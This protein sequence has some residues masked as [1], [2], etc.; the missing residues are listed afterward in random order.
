MKQKIEHQIQN[1]FESEFSTYIHECGKDLPV[2]PHFHKS[3]E[4]ITVING[5]C[6]C[7]LNGIEYIL[8]E[9]DSIFI[10]PFDIHSFSLDENSSVRRMTFHEHLILTV[11]QTINGRRPN[12]PVFHANEENT[13]FF[14]NLSE[15][16][17]GKEKEQFAR[18]EPYSRRIKTKALLYL[19]CGDFLS[20]AELI[21]SPKTDNISIAVT[22]YIS[23]NFRN[24][25]TLH[26]VANEMG[27][28][29]QYLSR[30]FNKVLNINFKKMLN[31][32]R[33]EFAFSLLQD[34][35]MQISQICFESGFQSL[36]TFNKVFLETFGRTPKEL[37]KFRTVII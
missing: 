1:M 27:Y 6:K 26:D 31:Q 24:N 3:Y 16:L 35:N 17:F 15:A 8:S 4:I 32:Y 7:I 34:T 37:R 5:S 2:P 10:C 13:E 30:I 18:I 28:N 12:S 36:R 23:K 14:L 19:L 22:K 20:S 11:S 29:Y 21:S 25:I 9:K 33:A